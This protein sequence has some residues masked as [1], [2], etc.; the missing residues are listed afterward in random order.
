MAPQ[1]FLHN[2][3]DVKVLILFILARIDTPL[4]VDAIYE[5][6]YQ[7][8]SLNYFTLAES[9]PELK[10]SGHLAVNSHGQYTITE[11]GRQHGS[12]VEDSLAVPV[13]EKVSAAIER[14]IDQLRRES[15]LVTTVTQDDSGY[16]S[17]NLKYQDEK[18]P[19][20]QLSL[21]APNE[22]LGKVMA[23]HMKKHVTQIYKF[24]VDAAMDDRRDQNGQSL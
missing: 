15:L 14:K 24:C 16:W 1:G 7:D 23:E 3:L 10:D 2:K 6:A 21:M 9:L 5:V 8:D 19:L 22:E 12:Y 13:V 18:M 11:K 4:D 20:M 17:A